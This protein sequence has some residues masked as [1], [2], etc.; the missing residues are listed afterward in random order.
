MTTPI[1]AI[2]LAGSRPTPDPLAVAA[3]VAIKPLAPVAGEPMINH[4]ARALL[5]HPAV[6]QV[7]ILTQS[8]APF[9]A[10]PATAWLTTHPQVRFEQSG[11]GIASSLLALL[12]RGDVP[13]PILLTTADH[14]LL[15]S[16]MLDQFT[17]EAAGADIAVAMVERRILLARYPGS[18]RTWLKFRDGWWSGANIFWFGSDRARSII[19]LWQEV[20]Q[21][22]KKGWK[23]VSA[24]GP[25]ALIGTL[26]RLLTL[27]GGI[28]RIGRRFGLTARLVAMEKAEACIDADKPDD[29]VLIERIVAAR[30]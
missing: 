2:L 5:A 10:D 14:V 19:A 24:F 20:E 26:L 4:P 22:R 30:G 8:S 16:A 28:A 6:G 25:V 27:R 13:F 29:V 7:V 23:I 21:D 1:T 3:G 18:R 17:Q 12:E 9:A 15:D 11:A